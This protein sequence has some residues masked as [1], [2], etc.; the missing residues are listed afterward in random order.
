MGQ[1]HNR[2]RPFR[3]NSIVNISAMSFGSFWENAVLAMSKGAS[4]ALAFHNTGEG[5]VSPYH[6]EGGVDI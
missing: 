4:Q 1:R 2:R 3:P 6:K 5:G